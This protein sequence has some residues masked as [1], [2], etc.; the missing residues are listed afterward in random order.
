MARPGSAYQALSPADVQVIAEGRLSPIRSL[1]PMVA[2]GGIGAA[3][4]HL[5]PRYG[6]RVQLDA[7][8]VAE[9]VAIARDNFS[10]L[11]LPEIVQAY[12]LW[13]AGRFA[14]LEM[15]GGQFTATQFGRVL[16]D[17]VTYRHAIQMEL[18]GQEA[19]QMADRRRTER[20]ERHAA[21]YQRL[22]AE[23][24]HD[25]QL[26]REHDLFE[27]PSAVPRNWYE[28]AEHHGMIT[29]EPGEKLALCQ[30]AERDVLAEQSAQ[31]SATRSYQS[32]KTLAAHFQ[33]IGSTP[34]YVRAKQ[35][36]VWTK[37]LKR[38]LPPEGAQTPR[39]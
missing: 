39:P 26:A 20:E 19:D 36:A 1:D 33:R 10:Q 30:R 27:R 28:L 16:A 11:G 4:R 21:H 7:G 22:V 24:P 9:C 12:R 23:F 8:V 18:A 15:Y 2:S 5:A 17:Y 25:V 34:I 29:Y 13:A 32:L 37:V 31:R 35:Y 3:I 14:S 38:K 6:A